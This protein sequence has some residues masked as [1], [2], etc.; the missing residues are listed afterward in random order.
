[1][2]RYQPL[3]I[4]DAPARLYAEGWPA[5]ILAILFCCAL[6]SFSV[7]VTLWSIIGILGQVQDLLHWREILLLN[8]HP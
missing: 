3:R 1:M 8:P 4:N 2:D 7:F 6:A 5:I